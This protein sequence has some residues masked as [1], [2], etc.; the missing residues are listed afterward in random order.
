MVA[1]STSRKQLAILDALALFQHLPLLDDEDALATVRSAP[2]QT[3]SSARIFEIDSLEHTSDHENCPACKA[4]NAALQV[5]RRN[6]ASLTFSEARLYWTARRVQDTGLRSGTHER[7]DAYMEALEQ[8][9]GTLQLRK[10]T[11]GHLRGYQMARKENSMRVGDGSVRPWK[12][13]AVNSTINHELALLGRILSHCRLWKHLKDYYFPLAVPKWSPREIMSEEEE[14]EFFRLGA[15]D[16]Q[17]RLAYLVAS[18]TNNTTAAGIEL[19]LLRL[20]HLFLRPAQEISEIY[21]PPEACKNDN[22]PRKIA[23]NRTARWA[24]DQLYRRALQLGCSDPDDF[25]LPFRIKRNKYDPKRA[26]GK[27]FLRKSWD[28]LRKITGHP[29][30]RPHDLRHN[31]ITRILEEGVEPETARSIAGHIRPEMTDY[32][33]HQRKRVKYQAV[34]KIDP[35]RKKPPATAREIR[36]ATRNPKRPRRA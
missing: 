9:F 1:I 15:R 8:F 6:I 4:F 33:S 16:P 35:A 30:L 5:E 13:R 31:C 12:R 36:T 23:L 2:A 7:D 29:E 28:R 25:L 26:A 20:K 17:A 10:I 14:Q 19:R 34:Q 18:V 32:Y 22:R 21:I 27:T 11:P 3:A 24:V